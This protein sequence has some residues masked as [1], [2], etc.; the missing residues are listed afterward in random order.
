M[1]DRSFTERRTERLRLTRMQQKHILSFAAYRADPV[2]AKYQSWDSYS[3][4][5]ATLFVE[6]LVRR[7]PDVPGEWYQF[8]VEDIQTGELIGDLA[9]GT[10]KIDPRLVEVGFTIAEEHWNKGFAT[11][12]L[13]SL[14]SYAFEDRGKH[15]IT[16]TTD[17]LNSG[18]VALL[19]KLNFTREAHFKENIWF[20]GKWGDEYVYALRAETWRNLG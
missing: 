4:A 18:C 19:E 1:A 20:K 8:A 12:A 10:N 17:V 13:S 9:M 14:I 7:D 2:V 3:L 6:D 16:A 15:R 5:D 11:E